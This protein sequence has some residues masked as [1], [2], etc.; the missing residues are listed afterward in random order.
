MCCDQHD[1]SNKQ[2]KICCSF[3]ACS[4]KA[5]VYYTSQST[6]ICWPPRCSTLERAAR[7][8]VEW[9]RIIYFGFGF[10][11]LIQIDNA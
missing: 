7:L 1:E 3:P 2:I 5:C 8:V 10:R 4:S 6:V 9:T 11:K